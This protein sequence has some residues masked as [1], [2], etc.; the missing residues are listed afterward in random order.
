MIYFSL[1]I[2][3]LFFFGFDFEVSFVS[4]IFVRN[5]YYISNNKVLWLI[6]FHLDLVYECPFFKG[7]RCCVHKYVVS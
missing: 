1:D 7:K 6:Q 5:V 2:L 4:A 3:Y